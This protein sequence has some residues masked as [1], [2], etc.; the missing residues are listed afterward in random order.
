MIFTRLF[1][2]VLCGVIC[3]L[4]LIL[5]FF[6]R[7]FLV[8]FGV[9]VTQQIFYR[10]GNFFTSRKQ[11][12]P[13]LR[14]ET[15]AFLR[16]KKVPLEIFL[17]VLPDVNEHLTLELLHLYALLVAKINV[18]YIFVSLLLSHVH[19]EVRLRCILSFSILKS[20]VVLALP[21]ALF[22]LLYFS[23]SLYFLRFFLAYESRLNFFGS[24][25]QK[26]VVVNR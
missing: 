21:I 12:E 25:I 4:S 26:T 16:G 23:F 6:G 13:N 20:I 7:R 24:R 19:W 1:I 9:L 14:C 22:D 17:E 11:S 5:L 3:A 10:L 15:N 18:D 8:W 2:A